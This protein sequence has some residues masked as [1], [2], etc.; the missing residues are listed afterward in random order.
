MRSRRRYYEGAWIALTVL[1]LSLL[2]VNFLLWADVELSCPTNQYLPSDQ[3]NR[4]GGSSQPPSDGVKNGVSV[5]SGA[6]V[7]S[8]IHCTQAIKY[9]DRFFEGVAGIFGDLKFT[10]Y[11]NVILTMALLWVGYRQYMTYEGQRRLMRRQ[12][13][14]SS[15]QTEIAT[16]QLLLQ[17]PF[18]EYSI[19]KLQL[20][21]EDIVQEQLG[22]WI[23]SLILK[24]S[25]KDV[26]IN[27]GYHQGFILRF[28]NDP[29]FDDP[30]GERFSN[31]IFRT[32][33]PIG[34]DSLGADATI[35]TDQIAFSPDQLRGLY[36]KQLRLFI[37]IV[38]S[39]GSRVQKPDW[40]AEVALNLE[41]VLATDPAL[42]RGSDY[43]PFRVRIAGYRYR[44]SN[45]QNQKEELNAPQ[46]PTSAL[47]IRPS[48]P[49]RWRP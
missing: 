3:A 36:A 26:A 43:N 7:K 48:W 28:S 13:N 5:P 10:D 23:V 32:Q 49:I 45:A 35:E 42:F 4:S 27:V 38:F 31:T 33:R 9:Q 24:N 44:E 1:L 14:I 2:G 34:K 37:W 18:V 8:P 41:F 30:K 11:L 46:L 19:H 6:Q 40:F 12:A 39:Y 29:I 17:G 25:G 21:K 20:R 15:A 22:Y 47:P 16:R